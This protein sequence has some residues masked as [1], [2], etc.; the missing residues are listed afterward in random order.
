MWSRQ[1]AALLALCDKDES[2]VPISCRPPDAKLRF[3]LP[4]LLVQHL[5]RRAKW[6]CKQR[7]R[8]ATACMLPD[9]QPVAD[10]LCACLLTW[11]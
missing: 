3:F 11:A 6:P 2:A 4:Q 5:A 8:T 7:S 10:L 9:W 1:H